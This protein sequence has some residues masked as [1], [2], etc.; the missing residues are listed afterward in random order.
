MSPFCRE[1]LGETPQDSEPAT[2]RDPGYYQYSLAGI[3]I[4]SGMA[5]SGH[6][7]SIIRDSEQ[8]GLWHKFNDDTVTQLYDFD[9]KTFFGGQA[10]GRSVHANAYILVYNRKV[11]IFKHQY[12]Q[13]A[14]IENS[15]QLVKNTE[16]LSTHT[17]FVDSLKNQHL[18]QCFA[19]SMH[20]LFL[21]SDDDRME[22]A[23]VDLL[24]KLNVCS[25]LDTAEAAA[26]FF[27]PLQASLSNPRKCYAIL[28]RFFARFED[29]GV[30]D[31]E[32]FQPFLDANSKR[33]PEL[34]SFFT[35]AM[36]EIVSNV[37]AC[38]IS[39]FTADELLAYRNVIC[40]ILKFYG[41]LSFRL[42]SFFPVENPADIEPITAQVA[43]AVQHCLHVALFRQGLEKIALRYFFLISQLSLKP[44]LSG[45]NVDRNEHF[46]L[47]RTCLTSAVFSHLSEEAPK[48]RRK[49]RAHL[50][51][52]VFE[53][54]F[55]ACLNCLKLLNVFFLD[56][57]HVPVQQLL[58]DGA[59]DQCFSALFA[60]E[61]FVFFL[62]CGPSP[63]LVHQNIFVFFS[64][65]MTR[66]LPQVT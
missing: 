66:L 7:F 16:K 49:R 47:L 34:P 55:L 48:L 54:R 61:F 44:Q 21:S 56:Q 42:Y 15:V 6:Y 10:S 57:V 8:T 26:V 37:G 30:I 39:L 43:F 45:E 31:A 62:Y 29:A 4:H 35:N 18:W 38:D 12:G 13:I 51:N 22:T 32:L 65:M 60:R 53:S 40:G 46:L 14:S 64:H 19:S 59:W 9:P 23:Y 41:N 5:D 36:K 52:F 3:V 50:K 20:R 2:K 63:N 25:A 1:N 27:L 33:L 24:M 28:E 17:M 11:P 58:A